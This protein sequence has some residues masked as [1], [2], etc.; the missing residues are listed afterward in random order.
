MTYDKNTK[1]VTADKRKGKISLVVEEGLLHFQWRDRDHN[2][3]L[4]DV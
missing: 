4:E 2:N 3:K 1:L